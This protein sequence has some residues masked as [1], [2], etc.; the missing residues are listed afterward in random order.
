V[1]GLSLLSELDGTKLDDDEVALALDLVALALVALDVVV[2]LALALDLVLD[3]DFFVTVFAEDRLPALP[4]AI[5][6]PEN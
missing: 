6:K 1:Y 3:L 4:A 2:A 5:P